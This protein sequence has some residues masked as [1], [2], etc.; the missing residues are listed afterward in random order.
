[1]FYYR[2]SSFDIP[3]ICNNVAKMLSAQE[4]LI[5]YR[6][7]L[8]VCKLIL[9]KEEEGMLALKLL[10]NDLETEDNFIDSVIN[11]LEN[12]KN[13]YE[14]K[15]IVSEE[16]TILFKILSFYDYESARRSFFINSYSFI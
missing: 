2:L 16:D 3:Y 12:I 8:V 14:N 5:F 4:N 7:I 15:S 11:Y 1:M 6:K 13:D 9:K 10:E